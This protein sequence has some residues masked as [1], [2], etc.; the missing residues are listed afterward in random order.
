MLLQLR[1]QRFD[2][3]VVD[4]VDLQHGVRVA[5][6]SDAERDGAA[7][8]LEVVQRLV[9]VRHERHVRR[10]EAWRA[11]VDPHAAVVVH[12]QRQ[13]AAQS[14]DLEFTLVG[15]TLID[16]E[17]GKA[18]RA[19]AAV[20]HLAAVGVEDPVA[21]IHVRLARRLYQ[22]QLIEADPEMAVGQLADLLVPQV[23]ALG[24]QIDHHEVVAQAVHLGEVQQHQRSSGSRGFSGKHD[25]SAH[26]D[27]RL[28][29]R[30]TR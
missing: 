4:I 13:G 7:I 17:A 19:V 26:S 18:A 2:R 8:D 5:H 12:L 11:H 30:R 22:Q 28:S 3:R 20:L 10:R 21:K 9:A 23:G 14:L 6:R 29:R 15:Q 27:S 1:S 24:D 25:S 16:D